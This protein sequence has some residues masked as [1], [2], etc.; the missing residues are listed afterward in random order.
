MRAV[1]LFLVAAGSVL[2]APFTEVE[3][4]ADPP[5]P[6]VQVHTVRFAPSETRVYD[7]LIFSCRYRQ[8]FL[9]P[10]RRGGLTNRVHSPGFPFVYREAQVRMVA[11]LDKH[12]AFRVPVNLGELR[13]QFGPVSFVTNAPV[14]VHEVTVS[15]LADGKPVWTI[16]L[17]PG[18]VK[19]P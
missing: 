6:R 2:G 12:L 4:T 16:T 18:Q 1:A 11:G 5:G 13:D 8:T 19:R 14:H 7:E 9:Q 3:L 17:E 15:A 10:D